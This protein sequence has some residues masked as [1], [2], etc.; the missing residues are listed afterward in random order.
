[1]IT[2]VRTSARFTANYAEWTDLY[3]HLGGMAIESLHCSSLQG[4]KGFA[5]IKP[6][7]RAMLGTS[8]LHK[9]SWGLRQ[10]VTK[11]QVTT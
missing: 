11:H 5:L 1:M 2:D 8:A 4:S 3:D 9:H 10:A 7:S 6:Y